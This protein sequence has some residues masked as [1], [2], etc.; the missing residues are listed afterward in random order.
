MTI[1]E[2]KEK[3]VASEY[4]TN[5]AWGFGGAVGTLWELTIGGVNYSLLEGI[6]CYRYLPSEKLVRLAVSTG[7]ADL[8]LRVLGRKEVRNRLAGV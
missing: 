8:P 3:A 1:D 6:A 5:N 4:N 2:F 7:G